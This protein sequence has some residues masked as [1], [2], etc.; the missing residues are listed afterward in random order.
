M[1]SVSRRRRPAPR[2]LLLMALAA[3]LGAAPSGAAPAP[4]PAPPTPASSSGAGTAGGA[5][6]GAAAAR[7]TPPA[8]VLKDRV[9]AVV[10][11]D[12]ILASDLDRAILVGQFQKQPGEADA[13][14]RRRVLQDLVAQRLRFHEIDRFGMEQV[15]VEQ[16][17]KQVAEVRARYKD[18]AAFKQR[19]KEVGLDEATLHQMMARQLE[20]LAF[21]D[22][23]LGP[24]VFVGLDDIATYYRNVLT[25]Q[26]QKQRLAVP[27]LDDVRDQIR[28]VL[29]QQRLT[30]EIDRWTEELRAKANIAVYLDRPA[31]GPLP[32]VVKRIELGKQPA[33]PPIPADPHKPPAK[34]KPPDNP[35]PPPG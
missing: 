33:A 24:Q 5:P 17:E 1:A 21:V 20:V 25:P 4:A 30:E 8:A 23:R 16:I 15:P 31:G 11:D 34:P 9:L 14:Y 27:P 35:K 10:D 18:E 32:P 26:L 3:G 6:G 12:P 7:A 29:R 19:L 2:A 22:E 13:A 28:G